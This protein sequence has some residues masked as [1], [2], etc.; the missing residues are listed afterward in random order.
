MN[1]LFF[2]PLT[3]NLNLPIVN[4]KRTSN[5][6]YYIDHVLP[7]FRSSDTDEDRHDE[8]DD[9]VGGD[10]IEVETVV[11]YRDSDP[12]SEPEQLRIVSDFE[13]LSDS[14]EEESTAMDALA[15]SYVRGRSR[16]HAVVWDGQ[17]EEV[18]SSDDDMP[19]NWASGW[20]RSRGR[21]ASSVTAIANLPGR[22]RSRRLARTA[23]SSQPVVGPSS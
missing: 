22:D 18:S 4:Q 10:Q 23:G 6:T 7:L 12:E 17:V 5:P 9:E 20:G 16:G 8:D 15:F 11:P 19:Y 21:A 2:P 1:N 13:L 3:T 14:Y